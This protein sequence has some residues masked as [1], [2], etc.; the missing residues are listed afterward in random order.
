[1]SK[2]RLE[3]RKKIEQQKQM[4]KQRRKRSPFRITLI[5]FTFFLAITGYAIF[6]FYSGYKEA[7]GEIPSE[8]PSNENGGENQENNPAFNGVKSLDKI[9]VLILGVD[10]DQ[11]E[12]GRTDT[13]MIAQYDPKSDT[14]K[15]ASIMRDSYVSIPGYSDN[16]I[17]TAFFL[18]G[19]E[20]VRKTIKENFGIDVQYYAVVNFDGF[21]QVI[22]VLAPNGVE[23]DVE[24]R[25]KY[26]DRAGGLYIDFQPGIQNL[27]G[28]DLLKYARFRHDAESDFGRVRRQQQVIAAVKDELISIKGIAKLPKMMGTIQPYIDTN[29][30]SKTI[31]SLGTNFL[32]NPKEIETIRIPV[33][34]SW[35]SKSY[36]NAG[37]VLDIN[38]EKNKQELIDFFSSTET[39]SKD[40]NK[41]LVVEEPKEEKPRS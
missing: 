17:N 32:M 27:D 6:Q 28:S 11:A 23:I 21:A 36:R 13:I 15:L 4:I 38:R 14:A 1:M 8:T 12:G 40:S 41:E 24:K 5:I 9:N 33:D 29:I 37:S 20:L 7:A 16:K 26:T 31:L 39:V 22:D 25:M 35:Q 2:S 19:P 34:G 18:G 10:T 3:R 30:G